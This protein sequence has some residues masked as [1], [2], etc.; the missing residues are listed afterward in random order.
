MEDIKVLSSEKKY[1]GKII[2]VRVD[3]IEENGRKCLREVVE[4]C[5]AACVMPVDDDIRK[6][7]PQEKSIPVKREKNVPSASVKRK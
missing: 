4:H 2:G 1:S 5:E 6:N 3:T 7:F